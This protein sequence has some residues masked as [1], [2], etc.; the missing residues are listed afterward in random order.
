MSLS[1]ALA[2][3]Q[4]P[5]W[6]GEALGDGDRNVAAKRRSEEN[7]QCI[8]NIIKRSDEPIPMKQIADMTGLTLYSVRNL[9]K[10]SIASGLVARVTIDGIVNLEWSQ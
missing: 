8:L 9:V 1:I 10:P 3:I 2:Q 7:R 5:S 6:Y 4:R